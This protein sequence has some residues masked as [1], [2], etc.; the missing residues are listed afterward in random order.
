MAKEVLGNDVCVVLGGRHASESVH[1]RADGEVGHHASS[2]DLTGECVLVVLPFNSFGNLERPVP[3]LRQVAACG[4]DALVVTYGT[5]EAS[6]AVLADCYNRCGYGQVRQV[7]SDQGVCFLATEEL[8]TWAHSR[9]WLT[10]G[11]R[12]AGFD[13]ECHAT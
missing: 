4:Y 9:P 11:Q 1:E 5:D 7:E 3:A 13:D 8:C 2:P 6:S 12:A 10:G